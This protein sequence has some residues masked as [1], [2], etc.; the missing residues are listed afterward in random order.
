MGG[1]QPETARFGLRADLS[2]NEM[3][4]RSKCLETGVVVTLGQLLVTEARDAAQTP[5]QRASAPHT[6]GA[7]VRHRAQG[8]SV[9]V[10]PGSPF[11]L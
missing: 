3:P 6:S 11:T 9:S 2:L 8:I 1:G 7:R 4:P 10:R 5:G